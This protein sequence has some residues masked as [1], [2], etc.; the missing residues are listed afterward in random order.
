MA[1]QTHKT[2]IFEEFDE[3]N[4]DNLFNILNNNPSNDDLT[5][6]L[7]KLTVST[8]QEFMDKFAPKVYEISG[9]DEN[10]DIQ[11]FYTTDP[12]KY[13][14]YP[15]SEVAIGNHIYYKMLDKL[16]KSKGS[17]GESNL[18]FDD[19]EI[20]EMLTPK[21]EIDEVR[22][23]RQ[24]MD[25]NFKRFYEAKAIGDKSTM[26][27]CKDKVFECLE[28]ISEYT[29][30][31]LNKLLPILIEDTNKKLELLNAALPDNS[32][33]DTKKLPPII[34]GP[35]YLDSAGNLKVDEKWK[36]K[37]VPAI[38]APNEEKKSEGALVEV[39]DNPPA[40]VIVV[41][42][43]ESSKEIPDAQTIQDKIAKT[44]IQDFEE[45][46]TIQNSDTKKLVQDLIISTF[47]P[48]STLTDTENQEEQLDRDVLLAHRNN[49]EN[50][51]IN[52]RQSFIK[53]MSKIVESLLGVKTFFD[54][55]TAEGGEYSPISDGVIISNCKASRLLEIKDKFASYMKLLGKDQSESR[56][57]F[58]VVPSVLEN[59]P[60]SN[61]ESTDSDDDIG[62]LRRRKANEKKLNTDYVSI[63][64][65]K[66]FL[67]VMENAKIMTVF[68]IRNENN[69]F[70]NLSSEE[71]HNK[72]KT[73]DSC[74]Y[75]HA[76]YAYPNF[77]LINDRIVHPFEWREDAPIT[78]PGIYIDAAYPAAG[79]LVASQQ[80]KVLDSYKL[81]YDKDSVCVGVDFENLKV[82]KAF[83][84][85][86]NRES[87]LRRSEDLIKTIN[88]NMFGFAFSGDE[89]EDKS[90]DKWKN[91][92]IHCARSL[93]KNAKTGLYKPVYQTLIEDFIAQKLNTLAAKKKADVREKV[94]SINREWA[95]KNKQ[96][97][98]EGIVNFL[99]RTGEKIDIDD[100]GVKVKL[101][102][103]FIG[104][105]G[106]VDFEVEGD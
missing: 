3:N 81:K 25:Y 9:K 32:N 78:L 86:F 62:I 2:I 14:R 40:D 10:G 43:Q 36:E 66:E 104:G 102:I 51:Y 1:N 27:R 39:K 103:N 8:F 17:S 30:S 48:M 106:Y 82:K 63:N 41:K 50:A 72:I 35:L 47:A 91:S 84:T 11:F 57:W 12:K 21:K 29:S 46:T 24:K 15:V 94:E 80:H 76:V 90:G 19:K 52:A 77:T 88:S 101:H 105:D 37:N 95:D 75:G 20:I 89:V 60:K 71:V 69:T 42:P 98:Y 6:G 54:H 93:A 85:K 65:M 64:A 67:E 18:K 73:F 33:T 83:Q 44:L 49:F 55:A 34:Y 38:A 31:S 96:N 99:L 70:S 26:D 74:K 100:T 97:R 92:Y 61:A 58:A 7:Q 5:V 45:T 79:L 22:T 13:K 56:I 53:E 23:I 87:V 4:S 59:P 16:Y 68:N 28:A